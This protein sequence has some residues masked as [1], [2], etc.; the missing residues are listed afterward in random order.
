MQTPEQ[1]SSSFLTSKITPLYIY[2]TFW[3]NLT[4]FFSKKFE[5]VKMR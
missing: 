5:F 3:D 1:L 4:H 2:D